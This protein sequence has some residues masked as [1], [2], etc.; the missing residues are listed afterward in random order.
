MSGLNKKLMVMQSCREL[1]E[2][3]SCHRTY[4]GLGASQT[5][6]LQP[7]NHKM[8]ISDS[9]E[10]ET[11]S[12]LKRA[13]QQARHR[14]DDTCSHWHSHYTWYQ[15]VPPS[16][17]EKKKDKERLGQKA[18]SP[19]RQTRNPLE[20]TDT[21]TRNALASR[22]MIREFIGGTWG[23]GVDYPRRDDAAR[24]LGIVPAIVRGEI[25]REREK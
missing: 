11:T 23:L 7:N 21:N 19:L 5:R 1:H 22:W 17:C 14:S 3:G 10:W 4:E 8:V 12:T 2:V 24:G 16:A 9:Y 18:N 15:Y 20:R 6:L 13:A 25:E